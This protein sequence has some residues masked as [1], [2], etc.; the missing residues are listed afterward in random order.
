MSAINVWL[1]QATR[2]LAMESVIRVRSEILEHYEHAVEAARAGGL[3]PEAAESR[4]LDAL[5]SAKAANCEYRRVLLTTA[6][7]KV[8]REGRREARAVCARPAL[9]FVALAA[10]TGLILSVAA[11][12]I[13]GHSPVARD[14]A[15]AA[16]GMSPILAAL[17]LRIDT[18]RSGL[19]FRCLKWVAMTGAVLLLYGPN[20]LKWS[21]LLLSC[22]WPIF[23]TER[24]RA[25]I[26]RKLPS[27]A[28]PRDLYL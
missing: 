26:R 4:A 2:H 7:E 11:L 17:F 22:A 23:W 10:F 27:A 15:I 6:E 12:A 16:F 25:S 13:T 9:K 21:W 18:P 3:T 20:T 19:I 24:T 5:G 1:K 28:W 8:L 14:L